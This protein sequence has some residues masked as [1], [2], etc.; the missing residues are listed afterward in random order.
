M[1]QKSELFHWFLKK[2]KKKGSG[3]VQPSILAF[4]FLTHQYLLEK[5]A[6][7]SESELGE[8]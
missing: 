2:K 1:K 4:F 6:E 8:E 7:V 5:E 3:I